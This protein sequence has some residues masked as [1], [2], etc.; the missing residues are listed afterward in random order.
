MINRK[1]ILYDHL[2]KKSSFMDKHKSEFKLK[3][4][5]LDSMPEYLI[6]NVEKYKTWFDLN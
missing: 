6:K 2:A 4:V 1:V 5:N 3:K